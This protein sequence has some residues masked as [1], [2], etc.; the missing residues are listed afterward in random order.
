MSVRTDFLGQVIDIGD[1]VV[2]TPKNYRGLVRARIKAF[3]PKQ[4]RVVY[5]NDWNYGS[6]GREEDFLTCCGSL[7]KVPEGL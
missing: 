2:T 3:T 5:V 1:E 6:P 4:V 7:V